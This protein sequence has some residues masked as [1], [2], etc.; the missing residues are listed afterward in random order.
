MLA[1]LEDLKQ[2]ENLRHCDFEK[3]VNNLISHIAFE[4]LDSYRIQNKNEL[5][6]VWNKEDS[7][8]FLTLAKTLAERYEMKP[9]EWKNDSI[10]L[11]LLNLFCFQAQG[12]FNPMA[13]FFS[14]FVTQEIVKAIFH[15]FSP[16]EKVL[17]YDASDFLPEF[18]LE[19]HC[20][21]LW[22]VQERLVV[23]FLKT[24]QCLVLLPVK[25]F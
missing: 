20:L 24:M 23:S 19:K 2:D 17:Y 22:L 7:V 6:N 16:C 10:E 8:E 14:G 9:A 5:P 13:A 12:V 25:K 15:K 11:K 1:G 3:M 18:N 4:A 21:I